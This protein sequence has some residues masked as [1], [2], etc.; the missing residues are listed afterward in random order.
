MISAEIPA[1]VKA[2]KSTV[3]DDYLLSYAEQL[4]N[5]EYPTDRDK[6]IYLIDRVIE[7]YEIF[8]VEADKSNIFYNNKLNE[9]NKGQL[10]K[11]KSVLING[12]NG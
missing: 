7:Q 3:N 12:I 9:K 5:C 8:N 4:Q 2:L 6:M 10:I 11:I 1:V